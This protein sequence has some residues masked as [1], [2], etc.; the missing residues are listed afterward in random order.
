MA[1]AL[2]LRNKKP[3]FFHHAK[4]GRLWFIS[5]T[6]ARFSGTNTGGQL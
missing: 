6:K 1:Y 3:P 5:G 4:I 2:L